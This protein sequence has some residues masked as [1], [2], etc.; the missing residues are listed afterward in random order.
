MRGAATA[1]RSTSGFESP[2]SARLWRPRQETPSA[3]SNVTAEG[4][5][6]VGANGGTV[7]GQIGVGGNVYGNVVVA[8]DARRFL[9]GIGKK[10]PAADL[11]HV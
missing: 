8:M 3:P 9:E 2:G 1:P 4:G 7:G 11:T 6:L 5:S 10:R